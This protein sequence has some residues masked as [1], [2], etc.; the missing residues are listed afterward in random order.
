MSA[1]QYDYNPTLSHSN[2]QIL[3]LRQDYI[4]Y[5]VLLGTAPRGAADHVILPCTKYKNSGDL[6]LH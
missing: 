4:N 3:R 5:A 6:Q 1:F 2:R